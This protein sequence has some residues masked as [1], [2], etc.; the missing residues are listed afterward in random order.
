MENSIN[1]LEPGG[2]SPFRHLVMRIPI[3]RVSRR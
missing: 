3:L 2:T 1:Y